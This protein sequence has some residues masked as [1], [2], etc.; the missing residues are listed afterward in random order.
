M[1]LVAHHFG[2]LATFSALRTVIIVS[3]GGIEQ[4][5]TQTHTFDAD[6][7]LD[8]EKLYLVDQKTIITR[9]SSD[10]KHLF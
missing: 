8:C 7:G 6:Q 1:G 2:V 5:G 3:F 10:L 9:N 4:G